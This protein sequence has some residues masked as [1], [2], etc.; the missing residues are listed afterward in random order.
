MAPDEIGEDRITSTRPASS[1]LIGIFSKYWSWM[2]VVALAILLWLPRMSGPID[3][4]WDGSVYYLLGTSITRGAGY[5]IL[6]EPGSPTAVQY[7][8]L[9]PAFVALHQKF[10]GTIDPAVVAP[11]LRLSFA[12]IFI[13]YGLAVLALARQFLY[14][15]LAFLATALCLLHHITIFLSDL[16]F[17]ELPFALVSVLFTLVLTIPWRASNRW[18]SQSAAFVLAT[19]AFLLRT[20]GVV[21][22]VAWIGDALLRRQWKVAVVRIALTLLPLLAWNTHVNRVRSSAEYAHPAYEYQRAPYQYSNVT[23]AENASLRNPFQ[24]ELGKV[25]APILAG[26]LI[27]NL[28]WLLMSVGET[29]SASAETWPLK[30]LPAR[31]SRQRLNAHASSNTMP[32]GAGSHQRSFV[33]TYLLVG[34]PILGLAILSAAGVAGLICDKSWLVPLIVIGTLVLVWI[35]PWRLQFTRYLMPLMPFL[36]ICLLIGF[37]RSYRLFERRRNCQAFLRAVLIM[38]L[39]VC[40]VMHTL[41]P[42]KLFRLRATAEGTFHAPGLGKTPRFFAHERSWQSW[43]EAVSWIHAHASSDAIVATS[44]PHLLYLLTSRQ[45][46]LPPMEVDTRRERQLLETVPVTYAIIDQLKALDVTRRYMLP[47]LKMANDW[48]LVH[49]LHS[50]SIYQRTVEAQPLR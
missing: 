48:Q 11:R 6:S 16:L 2:S 44:A 14:L 40:G 22:F 27:N 12:V 34:V 37:S 29:L 21:L 36:T 26:R 45:A 9:L 24:P 31:F 20:A 3:L 25:N 13:A 15:P 4:R 5:H 39:L 1:L 19:A 50:T 43:E 41:V 18:T 33:A 38:L 10:S 47:A 17:A 32:A 30:G 23:Y 28:P 42:V 8:P 35:T 49:E 46:V 7:P